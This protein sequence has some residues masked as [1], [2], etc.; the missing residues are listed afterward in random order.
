MLRPTDYVCSTYDDA[1]DKDNEP[2]ETEINKMYSD[3]FEFLAKKN[4]TGWKRVDFKKAASLV[5]I[6]REV[7]SN[8]YQCK[9]ENNHFQRIFFRYSAL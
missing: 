3:L 8:N 2:L 5:N 6:Q 4:I 1:F 9:H 7:I